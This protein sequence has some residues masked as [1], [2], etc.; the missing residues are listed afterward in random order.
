MRYL[1]DELT[2]YEEGFS[3]IMM[4][5]R[6]SERHESFMATGDPGGHVTR[7][8]FHELAMSLKKQLDSV[9]LSTPV[10]SPATA[11]YSFHDGSLVAEDQHRIRLSPHTPQ[12]LPG[13][14]SHYGRC[15]G[16]LRK[17]PNVKALADTP[18]AL[19][20]LPLLFPQ[21][22]RAQ[23]AMPQTPQRLQARYP[24]YGTSSVHWGG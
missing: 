16:C 12:K 19:Q 17:R 24:S 11:R 8:D 2:S 18:Q 20:P 22:Q 23:D 14:Y 21:L 4:A 6:P 3:D 5:S 7:N 15:F 13:R 10:P 1:L 9:A